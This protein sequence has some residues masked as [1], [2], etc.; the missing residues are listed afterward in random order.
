MMAGTASAIATVPAMQSRPPETIEKRRLVSEAT[1]PASTFP[2]AGVEA[3]WA[4]SIPESLPRSESGATVEAVQRES[5]EERARHPKDHRVRVHQE[6]PQQHVLPAGEAEALRDRAQARAVGVVGGTERR[7]AP[8]RPERACERRGVERV[9]AG[10]AEDG[11]QEAAER[12]PRDR[13]RAPVDVLDRVR[14]GELVRTRRAA[15]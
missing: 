11:D 5:R 3:T 13:G 12:R 14:G 4:N 7:Q 2:S 1:T 15:G 10:Q 9:G 6:H 8:D